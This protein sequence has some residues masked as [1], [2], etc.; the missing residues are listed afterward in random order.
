MR[1]EQE[2]AYIIGGVETRNTGNNR[3]RRVI[4]HDTSVRVIVMLIIPAR[5]ERTYNLAP[6]YVRILAHPSK[7][8]IIYRIRSIA[9]V[10]GLLRLELFHESLVVIKDLST[11]Y[12][13]RSYQYIV[14][15]QI[16]HCFNI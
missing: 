12:S 15:E 5:I 1:S 16:F 2:E 3:E 8:G 13:P 9:V 6:L 4:Y 11:R 7:N 14:A 10:G